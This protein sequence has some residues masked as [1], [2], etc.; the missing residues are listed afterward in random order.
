MEDQKRHGDEEKRAASLR[1]EAERRLAGTSGARPARVGK[2]HE[3]IV[4]ELSVHQIELEMQNEALRNAQLALEESR[5][6]YVDLYDFAPAGY[7]IFNHRGV[8][9]D[10]N[11][12]GAALLGVERKKLLNRGFGR[13]VAEQDLAKWDRHLT[14]VQQNPE[15]QNC[16]LLLKREDATLFYVQLESVPVAMPDA[17]KGAGQKQTGAD[18]GGALV[19]TALADCTKRKQT[20]HALQEREREL[21]CRNRI[22]GIFITHTHDLIF[23][24]VLKVIFEA[25]QSRCGIF[26]FIDNDGAL[27]APSMT[28]EIRDRCQGFDKTARFPKAVW[29]NNSW[30]RALSEK[31]T[32][33]SNEAAFKTPGEHVLIHRHISLPILFQDKAIGLLQ[34][35]NKAA[36]Y[37][38]EDVRTLEA[39]ANYIAP[40]LNARLE[41][42]RGE[43]LIANILESIDEGFVIINRSFEIISSNRA[44]AEN[45]KLPLGDVIGK[46]C[47][48]VSHHIDRCCNETGELCPVKQVFDTGEHC[49]ALHT[50]YDAEGKPIYVETKAFPLL[51]NDMGE[52]QTAIEIVIDI[53]EKKA[54][55]AE[56]HNLAFYDSLTGLPNRRLLQDRLEQAF[57]ASSRSGQYGALLAMDLDHF[58][59][60]ND[61]KGHDSGDLLLVEVAHRLQTVVR[62]GDTVSRQGG[63]EFV[64]LLQNL[65]IAEQEASGNAGHVA[66]KIRTSIGWPFNL[67]GYECHSTPSIG[68]T[69]FRGHEAPMDKLLKHAD[70]AMYQAK[71]GGRN[72]VRFFDPV[73]QVRLE[74]LSALE[75]DLSR[76]IQE[77]QFQLYYQPQTDGER[78]VIGAEALLRWFH[79]GRGMLSPM[80]FIPLA[81]EN[82]SILPIGR[83]AL[84]EA[85]RQLKAWDII[86][87]A[88]GLRLAVNVSA[89]HFRQ[90]DFVDEV[91]RIIASTGA[92]PTRLKL[93]LTESL[94]VENVA[95]TIDK[96]LTLKA[97]GIGFSMD[98]FGT[99]YSSLSCLRRLPLE[100][101]KIDQSFIRDLATDPH[102]ADIVKTIIAMGRTLGYHVIAEGVE[103]EEQLAFLVSFGCHAYQGQMFSWPVPVDEFERLI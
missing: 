101:L 97:I 62:A 69:L 6:R 51:R 2:T 21:H 88:S 20:E 77:R 67:K 89:R 83:W 17:G 76:A 103:T 57:N 80:E 42:R 22:A 61:T 90:P 82:G 72:A 85:C 13:F 34:V 93:E 9:K 65:A 79:P 95:D 81:E 15:K 49:A 8:I 64:V 94:I 102:N 78:R 99:G 10:V 53:T 30:F 23:Q 96:M 63:D 14:D 84:E 60:L 66:E 38:A 16:E 59:T 27:V 33:F 58:K 36:D 39:L 3:E 1:A 26:G 98:D 31:R 32:V 68:L 47:Y 92:D 87:A 7:F 86:P 4:H 19:R 25:M 91:L 37:T 70:V 75:S 73:M 29:S 35:A 18:G 24:E 5:D 100:Q 74:L 50:H 55:E 43:E 46:H 54:K 41:N 52:V 11:L 40:L 12:T 45:V 28:Q 48:E 71:A 44:Y 56:M